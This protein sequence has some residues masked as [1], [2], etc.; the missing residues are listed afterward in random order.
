[1]WTSQRFVGIVLSISRFRSETQHLA[2]ISSANLY[3]LFNAGLEDI[4]GRSTVLRW[5]VVEIFFNFLNGVSGLWVCTSL[6]YPIPSG[7]LTNK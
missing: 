1:V 3:T 6:D 4:S 2:A 7:S 5:F